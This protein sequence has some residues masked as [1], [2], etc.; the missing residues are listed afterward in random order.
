MLVSSLAPLAARFTLYSVNLKRG[1]RLGESMS[2]IA[3]HLADA[4]EHDIG[5]PVLLSGTSSGGSVALQ[6]AIDRRTSSGA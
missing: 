2:D 1:R 3:G 5:E 4:I 6:L